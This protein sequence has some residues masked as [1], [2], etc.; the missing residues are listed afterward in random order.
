MR[1]IDFFDRGAALDPARPML[2]TEDTSVSYSEVKRRSTGLAQGLAAAGVRP[3]DLVAV[4]APN[5]PEAMVAI[6]SV[7][8]LEA[9]YVPLNPLNP[10]QSN[11]D[12]LADSRCSVLLVHEELADR[13]DPIRS[14]APTIRLVVSLGSAFGAA[15]SLD[16]VIEA[17]EQTPLPDRMDEKTAG[18]QLCGVW[19]T[20]GTTGRSKLVMWT[21]DV[22]ATLTS[23]AER[24]WPEMEGA[25]NLLVSP[26]THA[27]GI[28]GA[29]F[30]S[31]GSTILIHRGFDAK[32]VLD[33]IETARVTHLFLP[34]TA[35]YALMDEQERQPRDCSSLK[36]LLVSAAPVTPARLARASEQFG[37]T[38]SQAWGQ[39]EAPFLI[40]YL[41]AQTIEDARNGVHPERLASC[42]RATGF[43]AVAAMDDAGNFLPVGETGE[44]VVRGPLVTPG[45][46]GQPEATASS[47]EHG[48]LHTGDVGYIDDDGYIYIL[49]R[50]KDMII[51]GGFNVYASEVEAALFE[52]D[53][54]EHCAVIG[55]PDDKWG[56]AVTAVIVASG[57]LDE[58]TVI[59]HVKTL[60][61]S[62]KAPK[63]VLFVEAI[64]TTTVGKID[65]NSLRQ[66]FWSSR[67]RAV[68]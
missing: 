17:G 42:G 68:N 28:M 67:D 18:S 40:A 30:A 65:K 39:A 10:V 31:T 37:G 22:W 56:E 63:K 46:L 24:C 50:K 7:W 8:R 23:A 26:M 49:D 41:P 60:V 62:I 29:L 21:N 25:V 1:V 20:G 44:L 5:V 43:C 9:V 47:R 36:M 53:E 6:I 38:V 66:E 27:A 13:V 33:A 12:L 61:G 11:I 45:Y 57:T 14:G 4:L 54:V 15:R 34:P 48:W 52:L 32:R 64:P 3:G 19:P 2:V 51:T 35:L 58:N 55:I 16:D 59:A